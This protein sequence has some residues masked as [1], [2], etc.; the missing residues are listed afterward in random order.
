MTST[1]DILAQIDHAVEDWA[2]SEDAMRSR[3]EPE[4]LQFGDITPTLY[5]LDEA[6][7]WQEVEGVASVEVCVELPVIDPELAASWARLVDRIREMELARVR[8][9]QSMLEALTGSIRTAAEGEPG[10]LRHLPEAEG[11]NQC[12]PTPRRDRPAWQSP[13]G[14]ARRRR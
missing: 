9:V 11:C 10:N 1:D 8:H 7:E 2:V 6:G 12:T 3:P 14:P 4:P 13:Y 5:T